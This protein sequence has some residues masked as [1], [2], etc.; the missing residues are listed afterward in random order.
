ME[1][2]AAA[3]VL[4]E[5]AVAQVTLLAV[6]AALALAVHC[7]QAPLNTMAA[8]AAVVTV[9]VAALVVL[10]AAAVQP[11]TLALALDRPILVAAVLVVLWLA[12]LSAATVVLV[13]WW[14]AT[15][16]HNFSTGE[17]H[18][19]IDSGHCSGTDLDSLRY[20]PRRLLQ[21]HRGS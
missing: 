2:A 21:R 20:K 18:E 13:S 1:L 17:T 12:E 8:V 3:V 16:L 4:A 19:T 5:V 14:S 15:A 9:A 6:M 7:A 10:V 11:P